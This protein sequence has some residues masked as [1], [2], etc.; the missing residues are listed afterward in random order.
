MNAPSHAPTLPNLDAVKVRL[1]QT[2]APA[3]VA[4]AAGT[5]RAFRN[6]QAFVSAS[7]AVQLEV[8]EPGATE[9][10]VRD[11]AALLVLDEAT[12]DKVCG[13]VP[14]ILSEVMDALAPPTLL[15]RAR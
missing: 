12:F 9:Q 1:A 3:P 8:L 15:C 4:E 5:I 14:T 11:C 2:P 10:F 7:L 6:L 13:A